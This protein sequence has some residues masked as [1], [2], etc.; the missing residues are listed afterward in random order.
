M[1]KKV[2]LHVEQTEDG[3]F[4]IE[5]KTGLFSKQHNVA[6]SLDSLLQKA[7]QLLKTEFHPRPPEEG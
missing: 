5:C 7:V 6:E 1:G 2:Q 3:G 4:Y